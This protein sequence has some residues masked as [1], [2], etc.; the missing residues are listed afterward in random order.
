MLSHMSAHLDQEATKGVAMAAPLQDF[1]RV[2]RLILK[3]MKYA[4][5]G[6]IVIAALVIGREV[7]AFFRMFHDIHP[8]L[9]WA[10][11]A[12]FG[13]AFALLIVR[14]CLR[15][16]SVPVAL[17]QPR[18]P[19]N[20]D[21]LTVKDVGRRMAFVE[22]YVRNLERN[23]GMHEHVSE[24]QRV[25]EEAA[26]LRS[27]I[28]DGSF[29]DAAACR[30]ALVDF[31]DHQVTRLLAPLDELANKAIRAEALAVG[32]GTAVSFNGTVDAFIVL[33]RNAN[34]VSRVATIYYGRPGVRG[35]LFILRDV[36]A[37][38]LIAQQMQGV[39]ESAGGMFGNWFGKTG[40]ALAGPVADGAVNALTTLRIGYVAKA[41]C[42]AFRPWNEATLASRLKD[43]MKEVA[44][45]GA[46]VMKDVVGTVVK[47]G[48]VKLPGEI[49]K[50][51]SSWV[52]GLFGKKPEGDVSPT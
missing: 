16:W 42:R 47:Q 22:R 49:A 8:V 26:S 19:A 1:A 46:G 38:V 20:D 25:R 34:L 24:V 35:S 44:S 18:L 29:G 6:I 52:S 12:L 31:E 9:G 4:S 37:A 7:N 36:S 14:P 41:R 5:L 45:Q 13:V 43:A 51:A 40:A 32:I 30:K 33:W 2:I 27:K 3:G 17:K 15:Y 28:Q 48:L 10:F 23:P 21:T 39:M 50:K 11:L